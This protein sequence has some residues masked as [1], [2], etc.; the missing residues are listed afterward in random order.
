M[1][2]L[3]RA[4]DP[5]EEG[6]GARFLVDHLW[7]RGVKKESLMMAEW[8]KDVAPSDQLRK[9]FG[10]DPAKWTGFQQRYYAELEAHPETWQPLLQAAHKGPITLL[11]S[12]RDTQH[13]NAVALKVFLERHQVRRKAQ[14]GRKGQSLLARAA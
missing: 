9:W 8:L 12:A 7:P 1:I 5:V 3:K 14:G 6:D 11:Y 13:N 2:Q 10:H 4:Y